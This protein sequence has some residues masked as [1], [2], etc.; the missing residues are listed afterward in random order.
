[1]TSCELCGEPSTVHLTEIVKKVKTT[2]HLCIDCARKKGVAHSTKFSVKDFLGQLAKKGEDT[3]ANK[4][5]KRGY[6]DAGAGHSPSLLRGPYIEG[7][8]AGKSG[9]PIE[10]GAAVW[11]EACAENAT[12]I[13]L[14]KRISELEG[15]VE[16]LKD[17]VKM[18]HRVGYKHGMGPCVCPVCE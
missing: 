5:R 8:V 3:L 12:M 9:I 6:S 2:T 7:Y 11:K 1:M 14:R 17:Q 10:Q 15:E 18:A 4:Q 16:H 13:S